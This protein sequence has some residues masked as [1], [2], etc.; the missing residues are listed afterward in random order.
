MQHSERIDIEPKGMIKYFGFQCR[1]GS[2]LR[3]GNKA[4]YVHVIQNQNDSAV[5]FEKEHY[6]TML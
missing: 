3:Y 1:S 2:V 5:P 4:Y 6:I